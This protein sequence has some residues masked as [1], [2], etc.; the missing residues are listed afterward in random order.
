MKTAVKATKRP[1][2]RFTASEKCR[3]VLL[4]WTEKRSASDLARELGLTWTVL[5]QWQEQAIG[6]MLSALEPRRPTEPKPCPLNA[7]LQQLLDRKS[8][9]PGPEIP[10]RP[11]GLAKRAAELLAAAAEPPPPKP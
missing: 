10:A 7:R 11:A 3:A 9:R 4:V 1:P 5:S 6:G 8:P 2:R